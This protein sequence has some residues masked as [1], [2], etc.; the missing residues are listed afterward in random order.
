MK[1]WFLLV[2][3]IG[4]LAIAVQ[5]LLRGWLPN[6]RNGFRQGTGVERES[7]PLGFWFFFCLYAGVGLYVAIHALRLLAGH[8]G[9]VAP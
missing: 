6:G 7:Q 8:G 3:G 9:P 4:L 2:L 5:G 1:A